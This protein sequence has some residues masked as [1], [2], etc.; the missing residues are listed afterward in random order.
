M[1]ICDEYLASAAI[2]GSRPEEFV[3][4]ELAT[5][6]VAYGRYLRAVYKLATGE[7]APE[8]A[9][10]RMVRR[11]SPEAKARLATPDPRVVRILDP[12][13]FLGTT[14]RL[15]SRYP[16]SWMVAEMAAA[17]IFHDAPLWFS[18]ERN[19]PP[20]LD[21]LQRDGTLTRMHV[22]GLQFPEPPG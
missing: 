1:I 3:E 5:T 18:H 8:G 22:A 16:L 15:A 6:P 11:L 7:V 4:E 17:A 14:A 12:R 20:R 13:P 10:T 19:V 21:E 2:G 9:L